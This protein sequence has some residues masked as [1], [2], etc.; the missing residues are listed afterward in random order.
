MCYGWY[1]VQI[2]FRKKDVMMLFPVCLFKSVCHCVKNEMLET[3]FKLVIGN[4][5]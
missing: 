2:L 3:L 1:H 4:T 5:S